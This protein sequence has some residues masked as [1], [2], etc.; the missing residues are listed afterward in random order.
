[1]RNQRRVVIYVRISKD[2]ID[3]TSTETQEYEARAFALARGWQIVTVCADQGKSAYKRNVKRPAFDAAMRMIENKQADVL[4][5][6]KLDRFYRGLDEF[7]VAWN[8]IR[9]AGGELVSVTE[10]SYDTT[11]DDPIIKWAI[12]GFAAMAEVESRNRSHRSKTNHRKRYT[13]GAIPNGPRPFGYDKRGKGT[14]VLNEAETAFIRNAAQRVLNGESLRSILRTNPMVGSTGKPLT[15]RGLRFALTCPRS[16]GYRLHTE[17]GNLMPGNWDAVLDRATWNELVA[18]FDAPERRTA[19]HNQIAHILSGIMSCGK[20]GGAMGSRTWKEG[21][22][23]QCRECGQSIDEAK[24]NDVVRAKV[25]EQCP[26]DRWESLRV[27]GRGFDP[28]TIDHIKNK[29]A[30]VDKQFENDKIDAD[31][32]IALSAKF[33]EQLETAMSNEVPDLPAIDNLAEGWESMTL[34]ETR[35]V[36]RYLTNKIVLHTVKGGSKNPFVRVEVA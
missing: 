15:V 17:T 13:D 10:P 1:M 2:R 16:A 4:L 9:T 11:S 7:N 27:Q 14:L 5:V 20:C 3:Q 23:Y 31:R 36:I 35:K 32:W 26:Q 8:R 30:A 22:R 29:L 19:P 28:A 21:Y 24:A 33:N 6:W 12:M 18:M 34:D 25:L